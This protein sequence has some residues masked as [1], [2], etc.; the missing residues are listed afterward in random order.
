MFPTEEATT[1]RQNIK[2]DLDSLLSDLNQPKEVIH[3]Q[4]PG[5]PDSYRGQQPAASSQQPVEELDPISPEV[6]ALTG[7][8]IA[9]TIDTVIGT[10]CSIYA[11]NS[12]PE[13]Y[14]A[15]EKQM[16]QLEIAWAA[17]AQKYNYKIEDSPWFNVGILTAAVYIPKFQDAKHDRRFAQIDEK[18]QDLQRQIKENETRL[19]IQ[20]AQQSQP[21]K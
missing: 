4:Q 18:L 2:Y 14:Q 17:V 20:A 13:K 8:T 19:N 3:N 16:Y 11:K 6:A 10:G 5:N 1:A 15:K 9:G 12:D 7:K 21:T